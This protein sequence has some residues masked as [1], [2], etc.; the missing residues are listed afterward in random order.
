MTQRVPNIVKTYPTWV[1]AL[2]AIAAMAFYWFAWAQDRYVSKATV[3]VQSPQLSTGDVSV[4]S[5][6]GGSGGNAK[7]LHLLRQYLLSAD[8]LKQVEEK[9]AF[10][11]HY[12]T[13]GDLFARLDDRDAPTEKLHDYYKRRVSVELD[14]YAGVLNI[15]VQAFTP[16]FAQKMVQLLLKAGEK[17]MNQMGQRLAG[18]QA[19][20]LSKRVQYLQKRLDKARSRL[21]KYQNKHGLIAPKNTIKSINQIV[22]T[23]EGK[24]SELNAHQKAVSSY[25]SSNSA[26]VTRIKR[27]IKALRKEIKQQRN[28]LTAAKGSALN[29]VSAGY[30]ELEMKAKFAREN[31]S[32][33]LS[34]L[35]NTKLEAAR[36]LKQV[37]ALQSPLLP[38]Y[39][40]RPDAIYNITVFTIVV[41][42][43]AFIGNMLILIVRE[44]RD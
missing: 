29:E 4:S 2:L 18:Q 26:E 40:T 37:S 1:I 35:E 5:I 24:R 39:P 28:R 16:A 22:A 27:E 41:L 9:L 31:Y 19:Q 32:A 14:D 15:R 33:V 38:E 43:L 42:F 6:L 11:K 17:H 10:R 12:S 13:N 3:I 20:F 25:K 34:S 21:V 23:L 7:D 44:H 8:M 36:K 30:K